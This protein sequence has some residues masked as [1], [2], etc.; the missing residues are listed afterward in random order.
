PPESF[1]IHNS[2]RP[3]SFISTKEHEHKGSAKRCPVSLIFTQIFIFIHIF[4]DPRES[5]K[6]ILDFVKYL[7]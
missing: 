7:L 4:S 3:K 2:S 6:L 1:Y 5:I